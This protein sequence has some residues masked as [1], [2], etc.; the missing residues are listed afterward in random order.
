MVLDGGD[1]DGDG[2]DGDGDGDCVDAVVMV[3]KY[4]PYPVMRA[5][6]KRRL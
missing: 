5:P 3:T 2:G 4:V 1:G 6:R